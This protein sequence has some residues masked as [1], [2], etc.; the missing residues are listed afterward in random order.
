[1]WRKE[2]KKDVQYL[3]IS[4]HSIWPASYCP[5]PASWTGSAKLGALC[6]S[7]R[8][9]SDP[10]ALDGE[11]SRASLRQPQPGSMSSCFLKGR[12]RENSVKT[13]ALMNPRALA[14]SFKL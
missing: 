8:P 9:A 3:N 13:E 11:E 6:R 12:Q 7:L 10:G 2:K 5:G 1:M 4:E 14:R